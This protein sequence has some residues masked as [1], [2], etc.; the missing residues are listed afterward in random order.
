MTKRQVLENAIFI[1]FMNERGSSETTA[2]LGVLGLEEV[3][4]ASTGAQH[5]AASCDFEAFGYR[6]LRLDTFWSSHKIVS[7]S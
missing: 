6:F 4:F 7:F 1:A 5:F 2:A 3:A